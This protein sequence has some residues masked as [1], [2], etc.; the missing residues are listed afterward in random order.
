MTRACKEGTDQSSLPLNALLCS[1]SQEL[2]DV[3]EKDLQVDVGEG[4]STRFRRVVDIVTELQSPEFVSS[5]VG[6]QGENSVA[7]AVGGRLAEAVCTAARHA[8]VVEA[9][10][11]L[12]KVG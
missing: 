8:D 6:R 7:M 4:G 12:V 1:I 3:V 11:D 9:L 5:K 10:V 2:V